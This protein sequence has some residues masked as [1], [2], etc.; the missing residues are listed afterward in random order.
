MGGRIRASDEFSLWF[1]NM[2]VFVS[3]VHKMLQKYS[4]LMNKGSECISLLDICHLSLAYRRSSV[5]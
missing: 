4:H 5:R 1:R 3:A 2:F